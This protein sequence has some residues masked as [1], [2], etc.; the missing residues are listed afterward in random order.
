MGFY[1][2]FVLFWL[3]GFLFFFL[4]LRQ[5]TIVVNLFI[6]VAEMVI[7]VSLVKATFPDFFTFLF[8]S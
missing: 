2:G 8:K 6:V 3:I 7:I 4:E 1:C 5:M